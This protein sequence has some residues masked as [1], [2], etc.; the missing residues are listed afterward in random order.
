MPFDFINYKQYKIDYESLFN[1]FNSY[2]ILNDKYLQ[3]YY[4]KTWLNYLI[5]ADNTI[6]NETKNKI[7]ILR[8][9][10]LLID[11]PEI[12]QQPLYYKDNNILI[13]FRI[14]VLNSLIS[15]EIKQKFSIVIKR[16]EFTNKK[17]DIYWT[18]VN[19]DEKNYKFVD[20]PVILVPFLMGN[21]D[22]LI[23]D[24]THRITYSIKNNKD[25]NI[26]PLSQT[27][28]VENNLFSSG[29]DKLFYIMNNE[30]NYMLKE[31]MINNIDARELI[32]KS[33]LVDGKIK[34]ENNIKRL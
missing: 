24:G 3:E 30:L 28:L 18:K 1:E 13:H 26:L 4:I 2:K 29:F 34:I 21:K 20:E 16:D 19:L 15:E 7:D 31:T 11:E 14:S 23:I 8:I 6:L 22:S 10:S 27:H 33:Y 12:F 32:K 5:R 25:I 9:S 17:S